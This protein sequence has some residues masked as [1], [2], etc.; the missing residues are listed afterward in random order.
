MAG[1]GRIMANR[2]RCYD[3][4][5]TSPRTNGVKPRPHRGR[6]AARAGVGDGA[7]AA[8]WDKPI[9]EAKIRL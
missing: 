8:K 3:L 2:W 5:M 6:G 1:R 9:D 4:W 7:R